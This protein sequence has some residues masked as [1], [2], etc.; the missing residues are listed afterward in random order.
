MALGCSNRPLEF[1]GNRGAG[2]TGSDGA[3]AHD[4]CSSNTDCSALACATSPC[5]EAICARLDDGFHHCTS[6]THASPSA[7]PDDDPTCCAGDVDCADGLA[8]LQ[9]ARLPG[10]CVGIPPAGNVCVADECQ[11]DAD[12]TAKPNGACTASYPRKCAYGPCGTNADCTANPGGVCLVGLSSVVATCL[13]PVVFCHYAN[14]PCRTDAD[15]PAG[16][17][18]APGA[19]L[20]GTTCVDQISP[21]S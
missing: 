15:C 13:F 1:G 19:G 21:P 12:C 8:C 20:T 7:C 2:A 6:R 9:A 18:C 10:V 4:T 14:D 17:V 3:G 16:K 11:S 5:P